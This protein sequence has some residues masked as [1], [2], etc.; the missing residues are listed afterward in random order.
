MNDRSAGEENS[1]TSL[2]V[3]ADSY[4]RLHQ[5]KIQVLKNIQT[6]TNNNTLKPIRY[7]PP[8]III[9]YTMIYIF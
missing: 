3:R 5:Y 8:S 9:Q 1:L 6:S 2:C 7:T 4:V